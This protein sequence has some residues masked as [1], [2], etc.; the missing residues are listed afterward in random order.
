[1]T[2]ALVDP[3]LTVF[4][5]STMVAQNDDWS[6]PQPLNAQQATASAA[7]LAAAAQ[8]VG[9]FALGAASKD[10]AVIITLAPGAYTA[11]VSGAN[12]AAGTAIVEV[13]ELP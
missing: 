3:R 4:S 5:G 9:A 6:T 8:S 2:G 11:Q 1:V 10:A 13:Y 12:A 7:E